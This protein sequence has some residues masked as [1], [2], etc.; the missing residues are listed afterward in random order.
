MALP[1]G[2]SSRQA[3]YRYLSPLKL[4]HLF[5]FRLIIKAESPRKRSVID[6]STFVKFYRNRP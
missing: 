6:I 5:V 1:A 3:F 4:R 2:F